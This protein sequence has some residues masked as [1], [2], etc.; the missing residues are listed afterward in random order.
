MGRGFKVKLCGT[1]SVAD[2]Q[3]AAE[4]G[5]DYFGAVV[6]VDFSPRCLSIDQARELFRSPPIP[7]VAL[8]FEM[9]EE[10][11][12]YLVRQLAPFAVQFLSQDGPGVV[13]RLKQ[14]FPDL[15]VWQSIHLPAEGN[16]VAAEQTQ[17]VVREYLDAGVDV[18]L[19]DTVAVLNGVQRFGGTGMTSDWSV[20]RHLM[21]A[22]DVPVPVYLAGGIN[23]ENAREA[24]LAVQPDGLD[25]CSGVESEPGVRSPEKV[26]ALMQAVAAA[27]AEETA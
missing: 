25:L 20:V 11:L 9:A 15:E 22:I 5:A 27:R 14:E 1:A 6:E 24:L 26:H 17:T 4:A 2:A 19:F 21:D 3:M 7:A 10:R 23:P 18:I 12:A 8:V 13:S 16:A